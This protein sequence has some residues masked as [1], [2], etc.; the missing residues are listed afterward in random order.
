M[1][2]VLACAEMPVSEYDQLRQAEPIE[3]GLGG[4]FPPAWSA[5]LQVVGVTEKSLQ[6]WRSSEYQGWVSHTG[7]IIPNF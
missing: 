4:D 7:A 3:G 2:S 6:S 5:D 1:S